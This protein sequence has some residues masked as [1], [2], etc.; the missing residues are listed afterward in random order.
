[1]SIIY[2]PAKTE[3]GNYIE[4][5]YHDV[6]VEGLGIFP[7]ESGDDAHTPFFGDGLLV[8]GSRDDDIEDDY[9]ELKYG[10]DYILSP[11]FITACMRTGRE[12]YSY[13]V[14]IQ[15]DI[16]H[17][18]KSYHALGGPQDGTLFNEI[19]NRG[20]FD[21]TVL[22]NWL[23]FTGEQAGR[24]PAALDHE[25]HQ[26]GVMEVLNL[27]LDQFLE[28]MQGQD[29]IP[30]AAQK[31]HDELL[32]TINVMEKVVQDALGRLTGTNLA[33]RFNNLDSLLGWNANSN[34][35]G[36][37][38]QLA[39]GN[40]TIRTLL[41]E[42]DGRVKNI[43]DS[44]GGATAILGFSPTDTTIG[45][46]FDVL[47]NRTIRHALVT[48]DQH[49]KE[50][51]ELVAD[52]IELTGFSAKTKNLGVGF[53]L[54]PD[55]SSLSTLLSKLDTDVAALK[56]RNTNVISFLG[57][58][59]D[60]LYDDQR[61]VLTQTTVVDL[62]DAL[63]G[64]LSNLISVLGV[65][66]SDTTIGNEFLTLSQ[67]SNVKTLLK[68]VDKLASVSLYTP[69][70]SLPT[71]TQ[72]V[73]NKGRYQVDYTEEFFNLEMNYST[74]TP[75]PGDV[76]ELQLIGGDVEGEATKPT[77]SLSPYK[78]D[79]SSSPIELDTNYEEIRL[80]MSSDPNH[81]FIIKRR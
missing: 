57:T 1:M 23:A 48:I 20:E 35:L 10:R 27:K 28:L 52:L 32:A 26:K 60:S 25:Y 55:N 8:L 63:E 24:D 44:S 36:D 12:V 59:E 22:S 3:A 31:K 68:E 78:V 73:L 75:Q 6:V 56:G 37:G 21:K 33:G 51:K 7:N 19:M 58:E 4:D 13:I 49:L 65:G 45:P 71:S 50:R 54:I 53:N 41:L 17:V 18:K 16:K 79:G 77:F 39:E 34:R 15:P 30:V 38:F 40:A 70:E 67:G 76:I 29:I 47:E 2:D 66:V 11:P 5:E 81:G 42:L 72:F 64:V 74:Y 61:T 14:I 62:V 9:T 43:G 80:T 69:N 46:S